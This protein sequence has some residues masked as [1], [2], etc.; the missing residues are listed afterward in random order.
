MN[1][2]ITYIIES[3]FSNMVDKPFPSSRVENNNWWNLFNI[4]HL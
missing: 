2:W 4:E 1:K 3:D